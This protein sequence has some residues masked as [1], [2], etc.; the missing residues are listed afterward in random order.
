MYVQEL[1]E[2]HRYPMTKY[3]KAHEQLRGDASLHGAINF[4]PV[5][6]GH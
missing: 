4:Q 5:G 2:G 6:F 3:E 1:P